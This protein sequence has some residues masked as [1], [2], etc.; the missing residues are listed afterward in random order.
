MT[1]TGTRYQ[2]G[3]QAFADIEITAAPSAVWALVS[4]PL[5]MAVLSREVQAV[6]WLDGANVAA[7]GARFRGHNA[8]PAIGEWSTVNTIVVCE[9]EREYA[10]AVEDVDRPTATWRFTL[11]AS[12]DGTRLRQT[13][14]MGPGRSGLSTAIDRWPD[15]EERIV[16][17]RLQEW[18]DGIVSNLAEFKARAEAA[19]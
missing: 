11:T 10:W 7:V 8:H 1:T 14:H 9:P 15:K 6:E 2:D 5:L 16:A 17:R 3:P 13:G 18:E 19:G 12:G 4:D